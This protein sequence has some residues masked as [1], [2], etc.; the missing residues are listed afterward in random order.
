MLKKRLKL[1]PTDSLYNKNKKPETNDDLIQAKI[2]TYG[3][4]VDNA[5]ATMVRNGLLSIRI[6][7]LFYMHPHVSPW[8]GKSIMFIGATV[9]LCGVIL[10]TRNVVEI[11]YL[12]KATENIIPWSVYIW[13]VLCSLFSIVIYVG[14]FEL[15]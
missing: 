10:Y 15:L 5:L 13:P 6:A 2:F 4:Q 3:L 11:M 1:I 12:T 14:S 9:I 8:I 7:F